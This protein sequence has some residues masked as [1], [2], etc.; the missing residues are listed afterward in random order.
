[1]LAY[2][3]LARVLLTGLKRANRRASIGWLADGL[4][5]LRSPPL[6]AVVTWAPTSAERARARGFDQAELLARAVARRWRAPCRHLLRRRPGAAQAGRTAID[7]QRHAGF[8]CV[9]RPPARIVVVDDVSTTGATLAAAARALRAAGA[10][11]VVA[12]VAARTPPPRVG[13]RLQAQ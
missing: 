9:R 10:V 2:D 11:E 6:D 1:L 5:A 4:A 8:V 12:L 13:A 7:R 3:D